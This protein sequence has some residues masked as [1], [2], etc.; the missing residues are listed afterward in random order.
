MIGPMRRLPGLVLLVAAATSAIA[1]SGCSST[2]CSAPDIAGV[3]AAKQA[4]LDAWTKEPGKPFELTKLDAICDR[5]PD[6]LS[7]DAVSSDKTVIEG[8]AAYTA[9]WGPGMNGFTSARLSESRAVRTWVG[10]DLA[11]TASIARIQG[12]MKDGTKLDMP[13]HLTLTYRHDAHGWRVVHE[14][15]SLGVKP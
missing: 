13:G 1:T 12:E 2:C 14:H 5:S 7:F 9:I 11:V 15:M 6:F 4:F 3:A 10:G 8:Y